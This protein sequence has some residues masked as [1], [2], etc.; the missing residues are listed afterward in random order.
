VLGRLRREIDWTFKGSDAGW[1]WMRF[2]SVIG[3]GGPPPAIPQAAS[4]VLPLRMFVDGVHVSVRLGEDDKLCLLVVIGVRE[5][6]TKEL[7]AVEDGYRESTESWGRS[8]TLDN[9]SDW[10]Q[11]QLQRQE[12]ADINL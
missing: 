5:D 12:T 2:K 11:G 1:L 7:L 4:R 8:T 3:V 10:V 6:G 9:C